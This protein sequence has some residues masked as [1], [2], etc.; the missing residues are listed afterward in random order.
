[1]PPEVVGE[2]QRAEG[3]AVGRQPI[4][5][6]AA[7]ALLLDEGLQQAAAQGARQVGEGEERPGEELH[8]AQLVVREARQARDAR[9]RVAEGA[10]PRQLVTAGD[11]KGDGPLARR[12]RDHQGR[13][14][15]G[16]VEVRR[17]RAELSL[18]RALLEE[19]QAPGAQ[20]HLWTVIE[21]P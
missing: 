8:G 18:E 10:E 9:R 3:G 4:Q 7:V 14:R 20:R 5:V 16:V 19:L 6:Q 15:I 13:P 1:V 2:R 21:T 17:R 11:A 12:R